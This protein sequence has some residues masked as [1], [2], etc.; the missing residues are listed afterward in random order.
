MKTLI[1]I[2]IT[3]MLA[4]CMT[5]R[6]YQLRK[7]QLDNQAKHP[8]TFDVLSVEGPVKVEI[9]QGGKARVT[10]PGQPFRE[11]PIPDGVRTQTQLAQHL[12]DI[13]AISVIGWRALDKATGS[14]KTTTTTNYNGGTAKP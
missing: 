5:E 12:I 11:I 14:H 3:L 7:H 4:G 8:A 10:V 2:V 1:C 9:S 6:E 13:G